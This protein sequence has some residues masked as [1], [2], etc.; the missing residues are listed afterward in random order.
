MKYFLYTIILFSLFISISY[1]DTNIEL[2]NNIISFKDVDGYNLQSFTVV[3]NKLVVILIS[4]DNDKGIIKVFDL[5]N[6]K[7]I[8]N[9]DINSVGHA[10][11]ITYNS[12]ENKIYIIGA[13]N[14]NIVYEFDG[15]T[16]EYIREFPIGITA[17]SIAYVPEEDIYLVR[18]FMTGYK[19]D[20]NFNLISKMP[21]IVGLSA[22]IDIAKQDWTY[23]NNYLYYSTWSWIRYGGDGS[24]SIYIYNLGGSLIET[25]HTSNDIGELEDIAF[26]NNKMILGFNGYDDKVKFYLEDLI[27]IN[28]AIIEEIEE[29][30]VDKEIIRENKNYYI[31]L[32]LIPIIAGILSIFIIRKK[33]KI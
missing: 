2:T 32:L 31:Y 25:I 20:N 33:R 4:Y 23:Y 12:K 22:N 21:F 15:S 6:Y 30:T 24:N 3:N 26:Y 16:Y 18:N 8:Q 27:E 28:D 14:T 9:I 29:N 5:Y 19:L 7:E 13:N 1:A 17:R 10:N 11:G